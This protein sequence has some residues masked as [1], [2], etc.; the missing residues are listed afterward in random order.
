M[1][2]QARQM[3]R[4][5]TPL[6]GKPDHW[7]SEVSKDVSRDQ[8]ARLKRRSSVVRPQRGKLH[9]HPMCHHVSSRE[10]GQCG[11]VGGVA[12]PWGPGPAASVKPLKRARPSTGRSSESDARSQLINELS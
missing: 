1:V 9:K 2:C 3:R 7:I 11:G 5:P 8:R 10:A 6:P 4:P 12:A